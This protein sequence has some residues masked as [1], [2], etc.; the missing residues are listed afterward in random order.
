MKT[1]NFLLTGALLIM[2]LFSVNGVMAAEPTY[3]PGQTSDK[4]TVNL[5]FKPVQS[6]QVNPETGGTDIEFV[7][8]TANDYLN[9]IENPTKDI[10]DHLIVNHTG[11]FSVTV[12]SPG[13]LNGV[14]ALT[15]DNHVTLKASNGTKFR[16]GTTYSSPVSLGYTNTTE[17]EFI[18]SPNGGIG[19][20]YNVE[21][22]HVISEENLETYIDLISG[23]SEATS[24]TYTAEVTYTIVSK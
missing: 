22:E 1:K 24:I 20:K 10:T 9:G 6:I 21:Y 11:A 5:I 17:E 18:S 23:N 7:Y 4:V 13:F 12:S 19:L 14:N 8:Q 16:E 3:V 15:G 2:A